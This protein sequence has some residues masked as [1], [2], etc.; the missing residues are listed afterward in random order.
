VVQHGTASAGTDFERL[1]H[2]R[3]RAERARDISMLLCVV[4]SILLA[5]A[6]FRLWDLGIAPGAARQTGR[7]AGICFLVS[8]TL[9]IVF[10]VV[11]SRRWRSMARAMDGFDAFAQPAP[12]LEPGDR[13]GPYAV[14]RDGY[15]LAIERSPGEAWLRAGRAAG[16]LVGLI[17]LGAVAWMVWHTYGPTRTGRV[18]WSGHLGTV[19]DVGVVL[20]WFWVMWRRDPVRCEIEPERERVTARSM[21]GALGICNTEIPFSEIEQVRIARRWRIGSDLHVV[22][23][24]PRGGGVPLLRFPAPRPNGSVVLGRSLVRSHEAL[25][26]WRMHRLAA[27]IGPEDHRAAPLARTAPSAPVSVRAEPARRDQDLIAAR[28]LF[29]TTFGD[30]QALTAWAPGRVNLIGDH[31]DYQGGIVLPMAIELGC[32]CMAGRAGASD[33][34]RIASTRFDEV[35]SCDAR[36]AMTPGEGVPPGHWA[37]YAVGVVAEIAALAG[38][39]GEGLDL[40]LASSLPMGAGLSSSAALEVSVALAVAE[41]WGLA[42]GPLDLARLCQRAEHRFAG[43]PCGL[44]DQATA[45][46]AH[47]GHLLLF[48]CRDATHRHVAVPPEARFFV[49]NTGVRHAVGDGAYAARRAAAEAAADA[50]GVATLREATEATAAALP[51]ERGD[52]ARHITGEIARVKAAALAIGRGDLRAAGELMNASHASL[53]DLYRVSCPELDAAAEAARD[54]PG[55]LG[56][57]MTGAGFGGCVVVLAGADTGAALAERLAP[58]PVDEVRAAPGVF[59]F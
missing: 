53:R 26:R 24:L 49:I 36:A 46:L 55:V 39:E 1:D 56:A 45:V 19:T 6:A 25:C 28:G 14:R 57:R 21:R 40:A 42:L 58:L 8:L 10:G 33:R 2:R 50:L 34:L 44:M 31:V 35:V 27:T 20:A 16:V 17:G 15:S 23:P 13:I 11:S 22:L 4:G 7:A 32:A 29:A 54:V 18:G 12:R 37:S 38:R 9:S 30:Q 43:S 47:D 59:A 48:D 3:V 5:W 41:L 52:A 51:A